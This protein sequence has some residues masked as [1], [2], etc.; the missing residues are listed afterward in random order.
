MNIGILGSGGV[1]K[2][3]AKGFVQKGYGVI[4]GTRDPQKP[5]LRAWLA[6]MPKGISLG[7]FADAAF[8][9]DVIIVA[10]HWENGATENALRL[11]DPQNFASKVV[12]D[13]T[14]PVKFQNG[15]LT[16]DL[17]QTDSAG[18][19]VQ[20]WLPK[21]RVVKAFNIVGAETMIHPQLQDGT[22]DM[23]IAGDDADAKATATKL[24]QEFGWGVIDLGGIAQARWL[25][26]LA[27]IWIVYAQRNGWTRTHAF[28]LL[29]K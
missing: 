28:K 21:A 10:T 20:H 7:S 26:A 29:R 19:M 17:A 27:L 14:N 3:L 11:A 5:E 6:N 23:F 9:G 24:L 1:G 22:A 8:L 18:E 15:Q 13:T 16:L 12:L 2:T 4:L 25:E